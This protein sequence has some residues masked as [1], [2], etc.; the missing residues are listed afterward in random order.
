MREATTIAPKQLRATAIC[1]QTELF[2]G[3]NDLQSR[4]SGGDEW[5]MFLR[6]PGGPSTDLIVHNRAQQRHTFARARTNP[7]SGWQFSCDL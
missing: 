6:G 2:D 5:A 3:I 4:S 1:D 7:L